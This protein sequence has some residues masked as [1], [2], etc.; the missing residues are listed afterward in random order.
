MGHY[1]RGMKGCKMMRMAEQC[2]TCYF[3]QKLDQD[4]RMPLEQIHFFTKENAADYSKILEEAGGADVAYTSMSWAGGIGAI[5]AFFRSAF[6]I[7][8]FRDFVAVVPSDQV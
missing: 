6:A 3:W 2:G 4:L 7:V 8:H 5:D 1:R